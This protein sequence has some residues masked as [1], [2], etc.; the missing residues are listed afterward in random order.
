MK[1]TVFII[2]I[3]FAGLNVYGQMNRNRN[4]NAIPQTN[5]EPTE[6]EIA[7]QKRIMEERKSEYI[8]NFLKTLEADEFQ[9]HIIKRSI[10]LFYDKKVVILKTPFERNFERQQAIKKL[11]DAHFLELNDL[12]SEGDMEKIGELVKGNFKEK[13]EKKDKKKE[14]KERK[15]KE[16]KK[17]EKKGREGK[18]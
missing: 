8:D 1:K 4:P 2:F 7:K 12:V 14:K 17:K 15:E 13:D 6:K 16:K 10:S 5:K 18:R 11:E 9:K 3:L